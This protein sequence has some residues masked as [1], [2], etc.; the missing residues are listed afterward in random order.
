LASAAGDKPNVNRAIAACSER[1][2][3]SATAVTA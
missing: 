2:V 1:S 3:M